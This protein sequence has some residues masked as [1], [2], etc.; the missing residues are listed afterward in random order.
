LILL[1]SLH[2]YGLIAAEA[3]VKG[4]KAEIVSLCRIRITKC[5]LPP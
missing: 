4:D 3:M 5:F 2:Y 1:I